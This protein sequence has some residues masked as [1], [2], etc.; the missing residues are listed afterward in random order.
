MADP[1]RAEVGLGLPV[2]AAKVNVASGAAPWK[3]TYTMRSTPT[4]T[5]ASIA[6]ACSRTRSGLSWAETR[7]RV[8]APSRA[9]RMA[10]PS[11]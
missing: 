11:P 6:V 1:G 8:W 7:N 5:A 9:P 10:S 3:D 4:A 2:V